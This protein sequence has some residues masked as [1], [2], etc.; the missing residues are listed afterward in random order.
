MEA[1]KNRRLEIVEF[2]KKEKNVSFQQ[3]KE[4]F[5]NVSDMTL[6]TDLKELDEEKK[7][8]RIHGGVKS[9][10]EAF[11]NDGLLN[12]RLV[13]QTDAKQI[14]A[15][16]I[17]SLISKNQTVFIDSGSTTT[18][19][20]RSLE[21]GSNTFYTNSV[22]VA[23]E[24]TRMNQAN[25]FVIGGHLNTNSASTTGSEASEMIQDVNFDISIIGVSHYDTTCGFTC[26]SHGDFLIKKAAIKN[27]AKVICVVD[28]SK[29]RHEKRGTYTIAHLQDLDV[30]VSDD[31]LPSSFL[32]LCEKNNI[33]VI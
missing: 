10:E 25:V 3:L 1:K 30:I 19:V 11:G 4:R 12:T 5:P 16:K 7:I 14:I 29:I 22:S 24:L 9:I 32:T 15:T 13:K 18:I 28:S 26:E 20:A 6:R 17:Q 23:Y 27:S 8:L 21:D 31:H 2:V 33:Q